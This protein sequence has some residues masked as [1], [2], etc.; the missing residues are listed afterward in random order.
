[1]ALPDD[2]K[3]LIMALLKSGDYTQPE[4]AR[5]VECSIQTVQR[6][7]N[8]L[9][10]QCGENYCHVEKTRNGLHVFTPELREEWERVTAMFR[11]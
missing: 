8:A 3:K 10:D 5:I 2:K 9:K 4:I 7:N 11:R 1:M 6:C